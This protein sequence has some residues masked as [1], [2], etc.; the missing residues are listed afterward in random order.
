V[1][2]SLVVSNGFP[3]T[4]AAF[5]NLTGRVNAIDTR[6]VR[7]NGTL[8]SMSAWQGAW[9]ITNL[10]LRAGINRVL[11]QAFGVVSNEIGRT[12]IDIWYDNG[13]VVNAGGTLA[14]DTAWT[15]NGGPYV[16]TGNLLVPA[17]RTLTV[18]AGTTVF[19]GANANLTVANGGRLV[20]QGTDI[21]PIRIGRVPGGS[22]WGGITINGGPDSPESVI[23]YAHIEGNDSAAIEVAD[24][25]ARLEHLTF[26]TTTRQYIA[27][28]RASFVIGDCAFPTP[29][30]GFEMVH[31]TGGIKAGG[32]GVIMRSFFGAPN[33]YNDTIDFTGGNRPGPI[34]HVIDNVFMGS[35]DDILDLD[36]TDAWVEGNIFMHAH[37]NGSPDSSSAVSGGADNA[38]TSQITI[39]G[40]IIFD[41]NHAALA[42]Q[43]N[44]YTMIN[45]TVVHQ[46]HVG[47]IDPAG[48]VVIMADTGTAEGAGFYLE[49]NIIYDAENLV[50]NRTASAVTFS[51]NLMQLPWA[52]PGGGNFDADPRFKY[53]PQISETM[54]FTTWQQAQVMK[55]WLSLRSGSPARG[56]GPNGL[57]VGG[58]VPLGMSISG[59]PVGTTRDSSAT[60]RVGVNVPGINF[61]NGSG[62]TD[63]RWRLDG[64]AWSTETPV[65]APITLSG[66]ADGAHYVEVTSKRDSGLYQDDP[67]FGPTAVVTRSRTWM[68]DSSSSG[69]LVI[70]E[71]LARNT[72]GAD[73]VELY[74]GAP[75]E[76]DLS[77]MGFTDDLL[78]PFKYKFPVDTFLGPGQYL[79]LQADDEHLGFAINQHGGGIFL[80]SVDGLLIDSVDFG[81]Q[82]P[83]ISIGRLANG[84][85][86]LTRPTF[87]APNYPAPVG[88]T[89]GLKIN[90]WLAAGAPSFPEDF[91]ELYNSDALPVA[92]RGLYLSD[93]PAGTPHFYAFG[94]LSYI[95]GHGHLALLAD[96]KELPFHLAAEQGS[97]GLLSGDRV[98]DYVRY[99]T[100]TA[101]LAQ[102][103]RPRGG[104]QFDFFPPTANAPNPGR[105]GDMTVTNI[106]I[107][108][109]PL[110]NVWRYEASGIDLGTAWRLADY[111][112]SAWLSGPALLYNENNQAVPF[113]N[114]FLPFTTPQQTTFYF[115][116][117]FMVETNLDGFVLRGFAY[118]SDGAVI[119]VNGVEALRVRMPAGEISYSTFASASPPPDGDATLETLTI[120]SA[121]LGSGTNV[122][123]VEVH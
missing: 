14:G 78:E 88:D 41:C 2:S 87:G 37:R 89:A 85:W 18:E 34:V 84:E 25:T 4:T 10:A 62:Y 119:H 44:S 72:S 27:V 107:N 93:E 1:N 102:G 111:D 113:R 20:A 86:A 29:T 71:V 52:G 7:V 58:V 40:N 50:Q 118:I 8:A 43:G 15:A 59:E 81:P 11:V 3:R 114:T 96:G 21:A 36:S 64:G 74:N 95:D 112:D 123:A 101:A 75:G 38:D 47:G 13:T 49:G 48:A 105:G 26:G 45:N 90:E 55:D 116:T 92:L 77:G 46:S 63:Y 100:Q 79:V 16:I 56:S 30:S 70:N 28:D 91:V 80:Y 5:A 106:A 120:S 117:A 53:V 110:T 17:G 73:L 60:L 66:L 9:G 54:N 122:L 23:S 97:I 115:R 94:P 104:D 83:D 109:L 39:I 69:S 103:R 12:T 65:G 19:L 24:G 42:K 98:L 99:G 68:V 82:V 35:G 31:G 121:A 22:A 61:T 67:L 76:I 108:L 51:N 57:D 33:G 6:F 32:H